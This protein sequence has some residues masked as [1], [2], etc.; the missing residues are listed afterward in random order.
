MD[1]G[2]AFRSTAFP[3]K[4][5]KASNLC[6]RHVN[7]VEIMVSKSDEY[8]V[9]RREEGEKQVFFAINSP[10]SEPWIAEFLRIVEELELVPIYYS[11]AGRAILP[12]D[13]LPNTIDDGIRDD[14]YSAKTVVLYLASKDGSDYED[15]WV[16]PNIRYLSKDRNLLVYTSNDYPNDILA[17]YG[18]DCVSVV[19]A[20]AIEFGSL[21]REALQKFGV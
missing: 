10:D 3:T 11:G 18:S 9:R 15:H 6:V 5:K 4:A 12:D 13:E 7:E 16:L 1:A 17:R 20:D 19:V 14:F 21:L 2:K 8:F